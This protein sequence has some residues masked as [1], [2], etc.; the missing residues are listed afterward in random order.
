MPTMITRRRRV[1]DPLR[2]DGMLG[3][4]R[5]SGTYSARS[6]DWRPRAPFRARSRAGVL[7]DVF[8]DV[9]QHLGA[10]S[11]MLSVGLDSC[12][13]GRRDSRRR[14]R[15]SSGRQAATRVSGQSVWDTTFAGGG[16]VIV[17]RGQQHHVGQSTFSSRA[18]NSH[19]AGWAISVSGSA[20]VYLDRSTKLGAWV[21]LVDPRLCSGARVLDGRDRTSGSL[22]ARD[23]IGWSLAASCPLDAGVGPQARFGLA[24]A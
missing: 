12:R 10:Y 22:S 18:R 3:Q 13:A 2:H 20:R 11:V 4:E 6:R 5:T 23:A 14:C 1:S 16:G 9:F 19:R 7:R 24:S 8:G 21:G 17:E 15:Q